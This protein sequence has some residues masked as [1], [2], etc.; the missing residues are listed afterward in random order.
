MRTKNRLAAVLCSGVSEPARTANSSNA[1]AYSA[2]L[3]AIIWAGM[4]SLHGHDQ[5]P[6]VDATAPIATDRPAI[7]NSSVVVPAG[8]FQ[9]EHS[10]LEASS[11]RLSVLDGPESLER[12]GI[13]NKE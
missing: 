4:M 12:F 3:L 11:H 8:S 9:L 5:S 1:R 7:T 2:A 10:L 13:T 6:S